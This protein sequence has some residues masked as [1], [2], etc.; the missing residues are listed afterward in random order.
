M[1]AATIWNRKP[2]A[3]P[4]RACIAATSA[5]ISI[6]AELLGRNSASD[7]LLLAVACQDLLARTADL[8]P[9]RLQATQNAKGI[10]RIDLELGLTKPRHV[11]MAGSAFPLISLR[12]HR[13]RLRWQLL[14]EC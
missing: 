1:P 5:A 7:G 8:R 2:S 9:V 6:W 13:R 4:D 14:S 11:R 3:Y 12:L 10:V